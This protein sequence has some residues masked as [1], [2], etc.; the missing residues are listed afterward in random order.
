MLGDND[1]QG[2][3]AAGQALAI[4]AVARIDQLRFLGDLVTDLAALATASLWELH[5]IPPDRAPWS[6]F[7]RQLSGLRTSRH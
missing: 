7:I 1:P 2:E 4:N 5:G 6:K 3:C